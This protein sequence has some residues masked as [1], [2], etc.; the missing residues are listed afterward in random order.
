[1]KIPHIAFTGSFCILFAVCNNSIAFGARPTEIVEV[2]NELPTN[3]TPNW[4][5]GETEYEI[6]E[7]TIIDTDKKPIVGNLAIVTFNTIEN[8][9]IATVITPLAISPSSI[10][11]GPYLFLDE[12]NQITSFTRPRLSTFGHEQIIQA[13][14]VCIQQKSL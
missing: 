8:T 14:I 6:D 4:R 3:T 10:N 12:N 9:N 2:I 5:V 13:Q 7:A 11:D 1:M